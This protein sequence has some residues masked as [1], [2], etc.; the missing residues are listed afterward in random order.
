MSPATLYGNWDN[1]DGED[2]RRRS[3]SPRT[4]RRSPALVQDGGM[5]AGIIE[6][7][8]AAGLKVPPIADGE[9][10]RR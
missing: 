10:E 9:C 4:P 3:T 5:M 1:G 6:A 2:R 8:E 7:F